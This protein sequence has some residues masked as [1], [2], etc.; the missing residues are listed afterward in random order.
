MRMTRDVKLLLAFY[1][2]LIFAY[3]ACGL[4]IVGMVMWWFRS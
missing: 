4:A 3:L 2:Y 1:Y